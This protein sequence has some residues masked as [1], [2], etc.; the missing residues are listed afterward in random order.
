MDAIHLV[1]EAATRLGIVQP[2]TI[3]NVNSD[4]ASKKDCDAMILLGALNESVRQAT[5]LNLFDAFCILKDIS[6]FP[7]DNGENTLLSPL[8]SFQLDLKKKAEDYGGL[9]SS[10]FFVEFKD[11]VSSSIFLKKMFYEL[12][13]DA[14]LKL[15]NVLPDD[16]EANGD[17]S[18]DKRYK[19][20]KNRYKI[21]QGIVYFLTDID[22]TKFLVNKI[23]FSYRSVWGVKALGSATP[24]DSF[25]LDTDTSIVDDELLIASTVLNYKSYMGID[26]SFDM[27]KYQMYVNALVANR[28]K[29]NTVSDTSL[30]FVK[31]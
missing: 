31:F 26:Y 9:I 23:S 7:P 8:V 4:D 19:N 22:M 21:Y 3:E 17:C 29:N 11:N 25:S 12:E 5:V 1:K 30:S 24:K 6:D 20:V 14:F 10:G 18:Y 15:R 27:A 16:N 2:S 13:D 28:N